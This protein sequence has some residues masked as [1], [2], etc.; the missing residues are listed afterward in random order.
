MAEIGL[1]HL[2]IVAHLFA[3]AFRD[4]LAL[5]HDDDAVGEPHH[6]FELVLDQEDRQPFGLQLGDE[7]LH[8][9]GLGRVHA[10]G[11]LVEQQQARLQRQRAGDL[12]AAAVGVGEA[13]GRLVDPR[14]QPLA[15]ARENG[16]HL[17]A[18]PFLLSLDAG[19]RS[20]ASPNSSSGPISGTAGFT[21]RS[22]VCAPIRT[23]S[24]TL[25]LPK[26]RPSWNVRAMPRRRAVPA[27]GR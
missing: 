6:H 4:L 12:D 8:L 19:G 26:T 21:A 2:G 18:Q 14:Q 25:R 23:L 10:G 27:K 7:A 13:V 9:R 11:R 16:L 24:I 20:S 15:E 3:R 22:R 1:D 5:V 17:L